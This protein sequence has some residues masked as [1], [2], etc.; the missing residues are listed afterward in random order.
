MLKSL[1][2]TAAATAA[3]VVASATPAAAAQASTECSEVFGPDVSG[4]IVFTPGGTPNTFTCRGGIFGEPPRDFRLNIPCSDLFG[5]GVIGR[6]IFTPGFVS[7][8]TCQGGPF[9]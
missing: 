4:V 1:L 2:A 3:L 5:E 8:F 9:G 7:E 6:I